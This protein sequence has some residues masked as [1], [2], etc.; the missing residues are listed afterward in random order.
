MASISFSTSFRLLGRGQLS[1]VS[2]R[3]RLPSSSL[4]YSEPT[5]SRG[6]ASIRPQNVL[7]LSYNTSRSLLQP[8][9]ILPG[10]AFT[11]HYSKDAPAPATEAAAPVDVPAPAPEALSDASANASEITETV[12]STVDAI[13]T[14][15]QYGDFATFGLSGWWPSGLTQW[16]YEIIHTA[17]HLPW[18]WTIIAGTVFWRA[19]VFPFTAISMR[20]NSRLQ[21]YQDTIQKLTAEAREAKARND[22]IAMSRKT[23]EVKEIYDKAGVNMLAGFAAPLVQLPVSLGMFFGTKWMLEAPI[24]QF[25]WSGFSYIPDLT[26]ADPTYVLSAL[27]IALVNVQVTIGTREM[28]FRTRPGMAHLMNGLRI[29]SIIGFGVTASLPAGLVASLAT[30][31]FLTIVQ[32]LALQFGPIRR[33][34][35]IKSLPPKQKTP[36]MKESFQWVIDSYKR[37]M[38]EAKQL[39]A[40]KIQRARS[41]DQLK[42]LEERRR[43]KL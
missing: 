6:F 19:V 17:T 11:R 4:R 18:F 8:T 35:D 38:E 16:S 31:S 43:I 28:D 37:K 39:E 30:A 13:H 26:V 41:S 36:S 15:L 25:K 21:P 20:N 2:T 22:N 12:A 34:F 14:P 40:H 7:D 1:K 29:F 27:L 23:M 42:R 5:L 24:E 32:S 10:L 33:W 9:R 3:S